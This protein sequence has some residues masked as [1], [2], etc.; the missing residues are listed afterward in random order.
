MSFAAHLFLCA[1]PNLSSKRVKVSQLFLQKVTVLELFYWSV[2]SSGLGMYVLKW[3][4]R[5][6]VYFKWDIAL[7]Q[8]EGGAYKNTV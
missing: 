4:E 7:V 2:Y 1:Q 6:G 5:V 8:F 3:K